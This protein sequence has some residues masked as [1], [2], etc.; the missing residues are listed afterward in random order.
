MNILQEIVAYKKQL[1]RRQ[2]KEI[3]QGRLLK[4]LD[5]PLPAAGFQE[6]ISENGI[7]LIAEIKKASPSTGVIREDFD[8]ISIAS[9]YQ[10]GGAD[11][12]SV[13]TEDKFFQGQLSFLDKIRQV[14]SLPLL[15]KDFII[16]E[17]Q[18]YESK[19]AGADSILLIVSLLDKKTLD[20]FLKKAAKVKLDVVL[21][22]RDEEELKKASDSNAKMI[23]INRRDLVDFSIDSDLLPQLL[24]KMPP[25]RLVIAESGVK[26]LEDLSVLKKYKVNAVL[27]GEALMRAKDPADQTRAFVQFLKNR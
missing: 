18:I 15:R 21:E 17:Y 1:L 24:E 10:E 13:L 3:P 9:A 23:G 20:H 2:K 26:T 8:F 19:V 6:K 16:D 12:L 7:H 22:V 4:L 27:I 25:D 5:R 11:C 14:V